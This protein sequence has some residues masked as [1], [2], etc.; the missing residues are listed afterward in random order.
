MPIKKSAKKDLRKSKKRAAF[1]VS[2]KRNI[3]DTIKKIHKAL[4]SNESDEAQTLAKKVVKLL[5]KAAK[6]HIIHKNAAAR[7]KS[8][9]YRAIS[10]SNQPKQ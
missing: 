2:Q 10:Q 6:Q 1:N 3:K 8:R 4:D 7:K 9:V 5:D